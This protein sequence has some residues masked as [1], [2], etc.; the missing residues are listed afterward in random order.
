VAVN[1]L[2][3]LWLALSIG[4]AFGA[5]RVMK[6]RLPYVLAPGERTM[7]TG[8]LRLEDASGRVELKLVTIHVIATSIPRPFARPIEVR[9]LWIRSPEQDGQSAPDLELFVDFQAP[10]GREIDADARNPSVLCE[11]DLAILPAAIGGQA[12]SQIRLPGAETAATITEG[13]LFIKN[14][15]PTEATATFRI[16]GELHLTVRDNGSERNLGGALSARLVWD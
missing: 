12:R 13:R 15:L 14:A 3:P 10:D 11:R 4:L 6:P 5:N 8:S 9:E 16:E 7:A 2:Q 1:R